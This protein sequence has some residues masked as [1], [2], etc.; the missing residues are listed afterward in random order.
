MKKH[1]NKK[2]VL[3]K[4][5][6]RMKRN[7][8]TILLSLWFSSMWSWILF[9]DTLDLAG[10]KRQGLIIGILVLVINVALSVF[11]MRKMITAMDRI[12]TVY[13]PYIALALGIPLFALADFLIAWIPALLWIGPQGRFDSIL[14]M[15]TPTLIFINSPLAF[16]SRI[17]GFFGIG[18]IVW[19]IAYLISK[20]RFRM[21]AIIPTA[22]LCIISVIGWVMWRS[23]NGTTFTASVVSESLNQ[24]VDPI[25]T[26]GTNLIIFPEYGLDKITNENLEDRLNTTTDRATYFLGSH[27]FLP[28]DRVG[29]F[30]RLL[31]GNSKDGIILSQD[32]YRLIPG[33]E[34]LPY[35]LRTGLRASNQ[36]GT[37]DYFSYAKGT[38]KGPSQLKMLRMP[39]GTVVGA[40][41][42]SSIIAPEDYR[43]FARNGATIFSNSASLTIFKGS[44]LFSWQ[45]KSFAKFMAIS[46]SR[47]FLQSANSARAYIL[48]N[49]GK[50]LAETTGFNV[51]NARVKNNTQ[52]TLYTYIGEHL[53]VFGAILSLILLLQ[54][55]RSRL[56][57]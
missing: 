5:L 32:K 14:P 3:Q 18:G 11:I 6:Q 4:L 38:L 40:A 17:I 10:N 25:N 13:S 57:T 28:K 31:Y 48:D 55:M 44:P 24:R 19:L 20:K 50:T 39:D 12:F 43:Y 41:V 22:F 45:Q 9:T 36:K 16:S 26:K 21:Y 1:K 51:I 34:D 35:I 46:N 7:R 53:V 56:S 49:N 47:Y 52:K 27:E 30:N 33:G 42:C 2:P 8:I 37:L 23:P 29:H 15:S 54:Y